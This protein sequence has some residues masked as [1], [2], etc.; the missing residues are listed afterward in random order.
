MKFNNVLDLIGNT[1]LVKLNKTVS[2]FPANVWAKCEFLNPGGSIKDRISLSMVEKMEK[3]GALREGDSIIEPTSGNTGIGLA[4]VGAV[5][6]YRVI[7]AM[8]E[9][10]S[11]EK[12]VILRCLGA[13]IIRTPTDEPSESPNSHIGLSKRITQ[14]HDAVKIPDQYS[15]EANP[16]IHYKTTAEEILRDLD[17][18]VD[19]FVAS[20]GTGGTLTGVAK[21]LKEVNPNCIIVGAD[22]YGSILGGG[23]DIHPY[24]VEGIGYDFYPKVF[25]R[26]LVDYWVKVS[27]RD[28]FF[29]A[30]EIIKLEGLLV[31]G[32]SGANLFAAKK[33][34]HL[35]KEGQN[36]VVIFP[37]GIRNYLS[38]FASED[39]LIRNSFYDIPDESL[40]ASLSDF[41]HLA[42]K[43]VT[44]NFKQTIKD[45]IDSDIRNLA[46]IELDSTPY[47]VIYPEIIYKALLVRLDLNRPIFA[48]ADKNFSLVDYSTKVVDF[49]NC[50][51]KTKFTLIRNEDG[52]DFID[53][54]NLLN[55]LMK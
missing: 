17:Y 49:L 19:M 27:D 31:G 18:K 50:V 6:G 10:M 9:K 38:K 42:N 51:N 20:P 54:L 35:L 47:G 24:H 25:N 44:L 43:V 26:D 34:L 52:Y 12:E 22:P 40:S 16:E 11:K 21:R 48:V 5:K 36:C 2:E 13:E 14:A 23:S 8:P 30:R 55:S 53:P 7:I 3:D 37:D 15:N 39:W 28:C 41:R 33:Y 1:P 29:T 32:S 45:I 4:L 46:V